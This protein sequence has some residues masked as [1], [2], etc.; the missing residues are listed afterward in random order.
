MDGRDE[1]RMYRDQVRRQLAGANVLK[2]VL[3]VAVGLAVLAALNGAQA[4]ELF[5]D[6]FSKLPPRLLSAPV[7]ELTNAIQEYHYLAHRGVDTRPWQKVICHDD[8]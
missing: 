8:A 7:K 1:F 4:G 5:R 3:L 6:D 2:L